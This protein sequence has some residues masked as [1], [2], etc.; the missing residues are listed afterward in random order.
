MV[1]RVSLQVQI[2]L[3]AR[4]LVRFVSWPLGLSCA[5]VFDRRGKQVIDESP[6]CDGV[7]GQRAQ[8]PVI[9]SGLVWVPQEQK[10]LKRHLP[11]VV[12]HPVC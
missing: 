6:D 9:D 7:G 10:V 8:V 2:S 4:F 1:N 3:K 5:L 12:H 11:R